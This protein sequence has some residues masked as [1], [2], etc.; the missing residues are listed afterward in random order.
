MR[1]KAAYGD[2]TEDPSGQ[3]GGWRLYCSGCLQDQSFEKTIR[4]SGWRISEKDGAV[5]G[6]G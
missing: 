3:A 2:A 4:V 6:V 5:V 1:K